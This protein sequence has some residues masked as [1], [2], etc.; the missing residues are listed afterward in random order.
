[1]LRVRIFVG[2]AL[3][4]EEG[5]DFRARL[6]AVSGEVVVVETE[7]TE[8]EEVEEEKKETPAGIERILSIRDWLLLKEEE[9]EE[10][11][12]LKEVAELDVVEIFAR[13]WLLLA[14]L[15]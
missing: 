7:A 2:D 9:G 14:L 13:V 15:L 4:E 10:L 12:L 5:F 1:L 8:V 3:F 11:L 6:R